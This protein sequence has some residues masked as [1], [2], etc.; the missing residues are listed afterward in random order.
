MVRNENS[1]NLSACLA[2]RPGGSNI[3]EEFGQRRLGCE[4]LQQEIQYGHL[5]FLTLC[6]HMTSM[7][8][9]T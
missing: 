6:S 8:V 3:E 4:G 5:Q 9:V 2:G 1:S 7:K